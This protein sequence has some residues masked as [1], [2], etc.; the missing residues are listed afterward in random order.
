MS[1][2]HGARRPSA[3]SNGRSGRWERA[4]GITSLE[5]SNRSRTMIHRVLAPR[6]IRHRRALGVPAGVGGLAMAALWA[7]GC[8]TSAPPAPVV[9]PA[10]P[11]DQKMAWMLQLEDQRILKLP[12][13]PAPPP[14]PPVK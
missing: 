9:A 14:E 6:L 11:L 3:T 13:P 1:I 12:E 2:C 7:A 8:A 4:R 5:P 10:V